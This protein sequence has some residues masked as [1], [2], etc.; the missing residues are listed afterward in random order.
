MILLAKSGQIIPVIQDKQKLMPGSKSSYFII[1]K[2]YQIDKDG[3]PGNCEDEAKHKISNVSF[4]EDE[5]G[6]T[7]KKGSDFLPPKEKVSVIINGE[8]VNPSISSSFLCGFAL[9]DHKKEIK[10]VGDRTLTLFTD[11]SFD[12]SKPEI[13]RSVPLRYELSY[14]GN[15]F[16]RNPSG[17]GYLQ[18]LFPETLKK[19]QEFQGVPIT[20]SDKA[21][22]VAIFNNLKRLAEEYQEEDTDKSTV[23]DKEIATKIT[24]PNFES[25]DES[26]VDP[27]TTYSAVNLC[28][29]PVDWSVSWT[30][31]ENK[32]EVDDFISNP[33]KP[34]MYYVV[35]DDQLLTQIDMNER[36]ELINL[37]TFGGSE[38][39]FFPNES[40]RI[41]YNI[42][43][44][45][46]KE[47]HEPKIFQDTVIIDLEEDLLTI[48]WK[49]YAELP[50]KNPEEYEKLTEYVY[51]T[52]E[53]SQEVK[54]Q[55][56]IKI[57]FEESTKIF[58]E[59]RK[60]SKAP[61]QE[62]VDAKI[63]KIKDAIAV[64]L[65]DAKV[66]QTHI[67]VLNSD[68]SLHDLQ[69][70]FAKLVKTLGSEVEAEIQKVNKALGI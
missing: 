68:L 6:E 64:V 5:L 4:N 63:L 24:L 31:F 47:L 12:I 26:T 69:D 56:E 39:I 9:T 23:L 21:A 15:K 49:C 17:T 10:V 7:L 25:I 40:P 62:E 60:K 41:F 35:P 54:S 57:E 53:N 2:A 46:N 67:D 37:S 14:G 66:D 3:Y 13:I 44:D 61:T 50:G 42:V 22:E 8:A 51:L 43:G 11:Q 38:N 18:D 28:A 65:K 1:K 59:F 36:I 33:H 58:D 29:N 34:N 19:T 55:E 70:Y 30:I 52:F 16:A 32:K 20:G 27:L 48:I 45:L